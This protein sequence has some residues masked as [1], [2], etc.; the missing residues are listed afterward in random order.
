MRIYLD[1]SP[2]IYLVEQV[3]PFMSRV[4]A[5]LAGPGMIL[6]SSE[7]TRME[8]LVKPL[9]NCDAALAQNYDSF[10]AAQVAELVPFGQAVFRKAADIRA[11]HNFRTPDA[12]HLAAA[13]AGACDVFL[14]NDA[15]LKAFPDTQWRW[16]HEPAVADGTASPRPVIG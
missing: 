6:V 13:L 15:G 9:R 2:I 14:T 3:T 5:R 16:C 11:K 12:L 1:A 10:F 8:A 4:L 7:L